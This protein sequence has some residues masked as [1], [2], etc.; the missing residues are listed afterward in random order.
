MIFEC[1]EFLCGLCGFVIASER[2]SVVPEQA[3]PILFTSRCAG[4]PAEPNLPI[5]AMRELLVRNLANLTRPGIASKRSPAARPGRLFHYH[6]VLIFEAAHDIG[7]QR[8]TIRDVRFAG[9]DRVI[10]PRNKIEITGQIVIVQLAIESHEIVRHEIIRTHTAENANLIRLKT[11]TQP[12]CKALEVQTRAGIA[13]RPGFIDAIVWEGDLPPRCEIQS[14]EVIAPCTVQ[15]IEC[16][17]LFSQPI[18]KFRKTSLTM[19]FSAPEFIVRLPPDK[20]GRGGKVFGHGAGDPL[21]EQPIGPAGETVVF[22]AAPDDTHPIG[23]L[24]QCLWVF[25]RDPGRHDGCRRSKDDL[26]I[27]PGK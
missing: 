16:A 10:V 21:R 13:H 25:P 11:D 26:H 20:V 15:R 18:L 12:R 1:A 8:R 23:L 4:A 19:A 9:P 5:G 17:V 14:P 24:P 27:V 3:V 7:G 22:S 2:L 6:E